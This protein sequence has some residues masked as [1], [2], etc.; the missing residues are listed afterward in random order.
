MKVLLTG[1]GGQLGSELRLTC[2]ASVELV[3]TTR[4]ELDVTR[5]EAVLEFVADCQ[6][7]AIIN[8]A[9]YTAVEGAEA[10]PDLAVAV[11]AEAVG[12][13]AR[14]AERVGARLLQFSTDLVFDGRS[15]EPCRPQQEPRPV[16]ALGHSKLAGENRAREIL[17]T[18]SLVLRSAWPY[19]RF[20][21]NFVTNM[22][23]LMAER[24]ELQVFDDQ[25]I[26][27]TWARG[28]AQTAWALLEQPELH[29]IYHWTDAGR[30]SWHQFALEI[31]RQ[32][33]A[34]GLLDRQVP[35]EAAPAGEHAGQAI[36]PAAVE[37]DLAATEALLGR[38]A[39]PWEQQLRG[40]LEDL[41][42]H[43]SEG[44]G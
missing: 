35:I 20:G 9:A 34:L 15:A 38:D 26:A 39:R 24:D 7:A 12:H 5:R 36:R 21:T 37:L 44:P 43:P 30:C 10:K 18:A 31:Q 1:A 40:M 13:L 22:L 2:P 32:A 6:P 8:A 23:R 19:S 14:A 27:P 17:P 16:N 33:L 4:R 11:N 41:S 25:V 42:K 29:G 3:A 28:L